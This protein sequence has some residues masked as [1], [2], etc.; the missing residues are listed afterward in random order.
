MASKTHLFSLLLPALLAACG[1]PGASHD[2]DQ[3]VVTSEDETTLETPLETSPLDFTLCLNQCDASHM[4]IGCDDRTQRTAST[5]GVK[6]FSQV[7]WFGNGCSGTLIGSNVVLSAAHCFFTAGTNTFRQGPISFSLGQT[8]VPPSGGG[9]I[10]LPGETCRRPYGT[11]YISSVTVPGEYDNT[12]IAVDN[13]AWDYAV[14]LLNDAPVDAEP[15]PYGYTDWSTLQNEE[16]Q[17]IGYPGTDKVSGTLWDTGRKSFLGRWLDPTDI[18]LSGVLYVDN[19]GEGGQSGS[20]VFYDYAQ[21]SGNG[22]LSTAYKLTGV[23]IGSPVAEC[24]A[25]RSW[26]ARI[27]PKTVDRI[28]TWK[29]DPDSLTYSRKFKSF[30]G[31]QIL[32]AVPTGC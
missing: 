7:G 9:G 3:D 11:Q 16:S 31:T 13:K 8:S 12:S 14:V 6:P 1:D 24:Q 21:F 22:T 19:D 10:G 30:T 20:P 23:L 26:A 17:S 25:G 2:D 4:I 5:E 15:M 32:P 28:D 29:V 18:N 27:L